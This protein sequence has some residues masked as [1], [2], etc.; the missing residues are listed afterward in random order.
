MS[1]P[2][3]GSSQNPPA[4][5]SSTDAGSSMTDPA[6]LELLSEMSTA[7]ELLESPIPLHRFRGESRLVR[8]GD[9]VV[10]HL[11]KILASSPWSQLHAGILEAFK[12]IRPPQAVP[13][14]SVYIQDHQPEVRL[15][16]VRTLRW[17]PVGMDPFVNALG[18]VDWRIRRECVFCISSRGGDQ[19]LL[20][21]LR[22][23]RDEHFQVRAV[24][25]N[26]LGRLGLSKA[27]PLLR[28]A[29]RDESQRVRAMAAWSLDRWQDPASTRA[30]LEALSESG[31][32]AKQRILHALR[33]N[34]S[35]LVTA[36]MLQACED[37][38]QDIQLQGAAVLHHGGPEALKKRLSALF[39]SADKAMQHKAAWVIAQF[40]I[41]SRADLQALLRDP[42]ENLRY[43]AVCAL[44]Y[45][46]LNT[47]HSCLFRATKAESGTVRKAAVN[48]L[49]RIQGKRPCRG[50]IES[51]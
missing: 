48:S 49:R 26:A 16:A 47:A 18:D 15:A 23:L 13:A 39:L 27:V 33:S 37:P 43:F 45:D 44:G 50:I 12:Q 25:A 9:A 24:A 41:L 38:D 42:E 14:V 11:L 5:G 17:L 6:H 31:G 40:A 21:L 29:L 3:T 36:A 51:R 7:L 4:S 35:P 20:P 28:E 19:A 1:L 46:N 10:P 34:P 22:A 2:F 30:L 8:L 32:E